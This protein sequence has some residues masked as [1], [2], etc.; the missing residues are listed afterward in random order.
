LRFFIYYSR[1]VPPIPVRTYPFVMLYQDNWDDFGN[2]CR[3]VATLWLAANKSL[4]LGGVRIAVGDQ[5]YR[6][7]DLPRVLNKL[8][9]GPI[10]LAGC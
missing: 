9:D 8:P 7:K 1:N 5:P 4:D 6:A 3:F 10:S 2:K